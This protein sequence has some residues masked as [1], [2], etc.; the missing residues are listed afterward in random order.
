METE[1]LIE[2]IQNEI[3]KDKEQSL[4]D[5]VNILLYCFQMPDGDFKDRLLI[6][7]VKIYKLNKEK[8]KLLEKND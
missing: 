3:K 4:K 5:I 7:F 6:E 2:I 1:R 8:I